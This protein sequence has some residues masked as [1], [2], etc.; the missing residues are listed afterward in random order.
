L[1][2][3]QGTPGDI[4]ASAAVVVTLLIIEYYY[5]FQNI[6]VGHRP[7]NKSYEVGIMPLSKQSNTI[8]KTNLALFF[9]RSGNLS[10]DGMVSRKLNQ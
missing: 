1:V 5:Y 3:S 6:P 9:E 2:T 4:K 7:R 8:V 10:L